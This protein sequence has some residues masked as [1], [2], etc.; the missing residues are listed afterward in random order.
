MA[1]IVRRR[2]KQYGDYGPITVSLLDAMAEEDLDHFRPGVLWAI[3]RLVGISDDAIDDV[4]PLVVASLENPEPQVRGMAVW[5]LGQIGQVAPIAERGDLFSDK[6]A[7]SLYEDK[8]LG[9]TTVSAL[10]RR[11]VSE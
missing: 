3:G 4:M 1:E 11:A 10:V 2:P 9:Q 8:I 7:V 6:S 5:C